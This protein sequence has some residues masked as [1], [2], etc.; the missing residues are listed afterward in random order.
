MHSNTGDYK[1]IYLKSFFFIF[2]CT[3]IPKPR[4]I[5][6]R[7]IRILK[8]KYILKNVLF[9]VIPLI[10][11]GTAARLLEPWSTRHCDW[12]LSIHRKQTFKSLKVGFTP[13][14]LSR[15][16]QS[17]WFFDAN[18]ISISIIFL[19]QRWEFIIEKVRS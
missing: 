13:F 16:G 17:V 7:N 1:E 10:I 11:P 14:E 8:K 18:D 19:R 3:N 4:K 15:K 2:L 5:L 9:V 6:N 12:K